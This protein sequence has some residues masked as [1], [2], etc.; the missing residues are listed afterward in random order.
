MNSFPNAAPLDAGQLLHQGFA[1]HQEGRLNEAAER[2]AQVLRIFPEHFDAL[3]LSGVVAHAQGDDVKA[4]QLIRRALRLNPKYSDAWSNLGQALAGRGQ[5]QDAVAAYGK[6]LALNPDNI[7]ALFNRGSAWCDI[8][9]AKEA[10]D[11]FDRVLELAPDYAEA[12]NFRS[13]ALCGLARFADAIAAANRAQEL[14]PD[15]VEAFANRASA[16]RSMNRPAAAARE[17]EEA[18]KV[19]PDFAYPRS[20]LIGDRTVSCDWRDLEMGPVFALEEAE[21]DNKLQGA[22]P[23]HMLSWSDEPEHILKM[24][25]HTTRR[26]L[27]K[28]GKPRP[29]KLKWRQD[30][31]I[32]IGYISSD[33]GMHPVAHLISESLE[34]HDR[35]RFEIHGISLQQRAGEQA[36]RIRAACDHY[37]EIIALDDEEAVR[38]IRQLGIDIAV[39]LNGYT[40]GERTGIF[41]RR[42]APVQVNF[43]G[44]AATMGADFM[45]Y[46]VVDPVLV[47]EGAEQHYVEKVV[48]LPHSYQPSDTKRTISD[49]PMTRAE[50]GLPENGFVFCSFNNN[51]KIMPDVFAVWMRLLAQVEGSVL[52]LRAGQAEAKDNLKAAASAHG[53]DPGRLIFSGYAEL[54]DHN[55]RHRMADLF[56]DT[57]P[58]N[59]HTTANDA[60]WSGLPVLTLAGKCYHSRVAASLLHAVGLPELVTHS[61]PEYEALALELARD[62]A[63]LA[64]LTA[65]L[66]EGRDASHLFDMR[67]WVAHLEEAFTEMTR[68]AR[69]GLKPEPINLAAEAG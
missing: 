43:L 66:R 58:Y 9:K 23:W 21:A 35:S 41:A 4:E 16:L 51:Y 12:H 37:H 60:L 39:C 34:L 13:V 28:S 52:W 68:R 22:T 31:P 44:F 48:R 45:D 69:A 55:A 5:F 27:S 67:Q 24:T 46:I 56:L 47:P 1:F 11:D 40:A 17:L 19:N 15:L 10:L 29:L 33:F 7:P 30:E 2:Y 59:A 32:R 54:P 36:E 65:R 26:V 62:P 50:W 64:A 49:R 38:L 18:L 20:L 61:L 25:R 3:H 14:K 63:R 42:A 57:F 6:A 8:G 53:I